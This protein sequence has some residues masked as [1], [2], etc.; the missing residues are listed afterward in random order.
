ERPF[1]FSKVPDGEGTTTSRAN[2]GTIILKIRRVKRLAEKESDA[3]RQVPDR[4]QGP[5]KVG[6]HCIGFGQERETWLQHPK[7]FS[8]QPYDRR[9]PGSYVT[10]VF[11]YRSPGSL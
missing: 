5:Q 9:S 7:T 2:L 8:T 11:R 1:T 6:D 4:M 3:P 10:F